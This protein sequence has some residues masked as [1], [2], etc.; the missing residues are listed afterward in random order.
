MGTKAV[1]K[2]GAASRTTLGPRGKALAS[3]SDVV[4]ARLRL[5]HTNSGPTVSR[6]LAQ[7]L[8]GAAAEAWIVSVCGLVVFRHGGG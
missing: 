8:T 3:P 4:E 5:Y 6:L 1:T 7:E 2:Y